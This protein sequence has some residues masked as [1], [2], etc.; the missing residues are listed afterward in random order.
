M[1]TIEYI[2]LHTAGAANG[3][4]PVH[5]S[6]QV[7]RDYH[8]KVKRWNDIGY[9]C[10]IEEDG[11]IGRYRRPEQMV[12]AAVEGWNDHILALCVSGH[13]DLE[14]WNPRQLATVIEQ[15]VAWCN[16]NGLSSRHVIGHHE[17]DTFGAP[18]VFKTCPGKLIDLD[19]IRYRVA[20]ARGEQVASDRIRELAIDFVIAEERGEGTPAYQRLKIE[21]TRHGLLKA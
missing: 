21:A 8:V 3:S 1:R 20:V 2:T 12:P 6:S 15:C 7:I 17:A 16:G 11:E 4:H 13:G 10:Y 5:Q 9:H 19:D 18:K 14:T